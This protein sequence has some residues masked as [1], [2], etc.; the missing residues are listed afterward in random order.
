M[1]LSSP[2]TRQRKTT[3]PAVV[4]GATASVGYLSLREQF[5]TEPVPALVMLGFLLERQLQKYRH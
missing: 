4:L 1:L 3:I 5:M 2:H